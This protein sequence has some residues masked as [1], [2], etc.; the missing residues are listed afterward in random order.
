[1]PGCKKSSGARELFCS[2]PVIELLNL[3]W[4]TDGSHFMT[5]S[6]RIAPHLPY[7]RR[8]SRALTGTQTSGDA[9]VA[10]VLEAIIADISIFPD[11]SNDRVALYKLFT[12]LFGSSAVQV[13]EPTSPYAWEKRAS[14]NLAKVSP[15]ARQAFILASVENFRLPEIAEILGFDE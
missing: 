9:Y 8:Y 15:V 13:P 1:M 7:L 6:T 14:V 2:L 3:P 10:A 11:T 12:T 5:L 4:P